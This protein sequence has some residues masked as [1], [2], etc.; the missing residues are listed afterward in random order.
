[1][2]NRLSRL[3][4]SQLSRFLSHFTAAILS[5]RRTPLQNGQLE[6]TDTL[7]SA[8]CSE[9]Y[10]KNGN[11]GA[12]YYSTELQTFKYFAVF[13]QFIECIPLRY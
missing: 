12:L 5:I 3:K 10:L 9:K 8:L 11:V 6:T 1:M 4:Y 13:L 2:V 7:R